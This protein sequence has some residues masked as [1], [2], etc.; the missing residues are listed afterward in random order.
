[1]RR[2]EF[3]GKA[4]ELG[5]TAG[6]MAAVGGLPATAA[7]GTGQ[8]TTDMQA[9]AKRFREA[10]ITTLMT[11]MEV[12]LNAKSRYELM[13]S[14]G[15]ACARRSEMISLARSCRGDVAKLVKALAG[16]LGGKGSFIEGNT[17][18][19]TYS[20]CYCE[21]VAEGPERLPETYCH[22]SE[23]WVKEV[24]STAARREVQVRTLQTIKRGAASCRFRIVL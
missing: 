15:R 11:N 23:G 19:L 22:C 6:G 7:A 14:C 24:F 4:L 3:L 17:V 18:Q 20:R 21:L 2:K 5:L 9:R 8:Q 13:E 10:W 1:M 12:K 16:F